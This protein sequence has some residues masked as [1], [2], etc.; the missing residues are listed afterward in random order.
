MTEQKKTKTAN[1]ETSR[2]ETQ[3]LSIRYDAK[4]SS[5]ENHKID[6]ISLANSILGLTT[7]IKEAD[8]E[9]NKKTSLDVYVSAPAKEGSVIIDFLIT[10]AATYGMSVLKYLGLSVASAQIVK[11]SALAIAKRI[12]DKPVL[13]VIKKTGSDE[14]ELELEGERIECDENVAKLVTNSRIRKAMSDLIA[15][16]L[17]GKK[18]ASF[19]VI[20]NDQETI[21][22]TNEATQDFTPISAKPVL[23]DPI[24]K[25]I[26]AEVKLTQISFTSK[27]N[28][29]MFYDN[30][31]RNVSINDE[32]FLDKVRN[33]SQ[34]FQEGDMFKVELEIVQKILPKTVRTDYTIKRVLRHRVSADRKLV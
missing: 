25:V 18:D 20:L 31:E 8:R 22:F 15:K 19:K 1:A 27:N 26:T 13:S 30:A 10:G 3:K 24:S 9:I 29:R 34:S 12:K 6:A 5:L 7:M 21:Q 16:P 28:W 14:V 23:E 32:A 33:S 11:G 2:I 17:S 4:G